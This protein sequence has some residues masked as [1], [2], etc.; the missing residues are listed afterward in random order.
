YWVTPGRYYISG[1]TAP[2]P[3]R[4][5]NPNAIASPNEVPGQS[6]SLSFYPGVADGRAS[7]PIDVNSGVDL[8]GI[9]FTVAPQHLYR[10]RGLV[11]DSKTGQPPPA[12]AVSLAYRT[13]AGVS[14]SFSSRAKYDAATGRFE[15]QDVPA[16]SYFVQA[17]GSDAPLT[18]NSELILN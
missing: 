2:G 8:N 5:L 18:A 16:G 11:I 1:G 6:Y 10:V 17:V 3:N 13:L 7:I 14:G 15:L 12:A 4:P 9:D